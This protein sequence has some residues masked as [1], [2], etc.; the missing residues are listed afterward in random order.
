MVN[1]NNPNVFILQI[2]LKHSF[3]IQALK[4]NPKWMNIFI[5]L[6]AVRVSYGKNV[7]MLNDAKII[8]VIIVINHSNKLELPNTTRCAVP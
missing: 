4:I 6:I 1:S 3:K 5:I 2:D 7:N 8:T